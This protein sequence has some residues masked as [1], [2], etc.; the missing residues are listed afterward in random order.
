M[1]QIYTC[2]PLGSTQV[3]QEKCT[4]VL[5][6]GAQEVS[7]VHMSLQAQYAMHAHDLDAAAAFLEES[8][9][10]HNPDDWAGF[11]L[12]MACKL[13]HAALPF[14]DAAQ[15][16]LEIQGGF[17]TSAGTFKSQSFWD[18]NLGPAS[19]DDCQKQIQEMKAFI[20]KVIG[21]VVPVYSA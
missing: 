18:R 5:L 10:E 15:G 11:M 9:L 8:L 6:E 2:M 12:L 16:L 7:S 1:D 4:S 17:S 13:P 19:K 20:D 3:C 14:D 21:Q